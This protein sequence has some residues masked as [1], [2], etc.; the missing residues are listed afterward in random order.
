MAAAV[1]R[2]ANLMRLVKTEKC[3]STNCRKTLG[4]SRQEETGISL[5]SVQVNVSLRQSDRWLL[6]TSFGS[7]R[8]RS[9]S[10]RRSI[11][12]VLSSLFSLCQN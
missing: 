2:D 3:F 11:Y 6:T 8:I 7:P 4:F 9:V 1:S 5:T 12:S 10:D